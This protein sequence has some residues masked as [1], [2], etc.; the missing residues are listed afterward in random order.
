MIDRKIKVYECNKKRHCR[1]NFYCDQ[2]RYTTD[3][4]FALNGSKVLE[5]E[6]EIRS[7]DNRKIA[8]VFRESGEVVE[9]DEDSQR[10]MMYLT[11]GLSYT[12]EKSME[13]H[14]K[15]GRLK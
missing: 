2:C 4:V 8:F 11:D 13:I 12:D 5:F 14:R 3:K 6:K 10:R 9:W 15:E 1:F 7:K